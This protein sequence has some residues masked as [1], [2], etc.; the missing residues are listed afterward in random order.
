MCKELVPTFVHLHGTGV[1]KGNQE[2]TERDGAP[3]LAQ[4]WGGINCLKTSFLTAYRLG[5]KL[6][7]NLL[8]CCAV[9]AAAEGSVAQS[10]AAFMVLM[11]KNGS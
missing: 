3:G 2:Y 10:C 6:G 8:T 1:G 7:R 9:G 4:I 11:G 5:S